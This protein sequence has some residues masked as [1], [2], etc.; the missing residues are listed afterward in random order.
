M[1]DRNKHIDLKNQF[2]LDRNHRNSIL[3]K[4]VPTARTL[5]DVFT[6]RRFKQKLVSFLKQIGTKI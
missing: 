5:A 3:Q 2:D 1:R 6:K 4:H